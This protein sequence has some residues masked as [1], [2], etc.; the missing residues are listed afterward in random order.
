MTWTASTFKA[1]WEEFSP[2]TDALVLAALAEATAELDERVFDA[3]FDHAVGLLA[4]HKLAV[5]PFGQMARLVAED[6]ST[7]Y[8]KELAKL[9]RKKAGGVWAVGLKPDGSVL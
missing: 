2:Q 4:A 3:S 9:S 8:E 1:R 7:T 5:S 6:G